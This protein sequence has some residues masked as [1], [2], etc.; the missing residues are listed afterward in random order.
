M[1]VTAQMGVCN[2]L[3]PSILTLVCGGR[4]SVQSHTGLWCAA[5]E[6]EGSPPFPLLPWFQ[7]VAQV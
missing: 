5:E 2:C 3:P 7:N 1:L 4:N 6:H